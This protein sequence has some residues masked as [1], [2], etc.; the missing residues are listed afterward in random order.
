MPPVI[1]RAIW[2]V[3][4]TSPVIADGAV[5]VSDGRIQDIGSWQ[6]IKRK[7]PG[8]PV[9]ENADVLMPGLVNAHMHLE[10]SV[11]GATE[12]VNKESSMCNWIRALLKKR[13]AA[14]NTEAEILAA[15]ELA[16]VDQYE[17]GVVLLLDTGNTQL[18]EFSPFTKTPE[19]VS[20]LE[21]LGPSK[22]A[23]QMAIEAL[24]AIPA[25][26][27][28]TGHAPY[29]TA[30]ELLQYIKKRS[31]AK[32]TIFSLH[33]AENPDEALLLLQGKGCFVDFLRER[34]AFDGTFPIAKSKSVIEYLYDS[35]LLDANTLCVHCVH[36]D[37]NEIAILGQSKSHI[38]LCPK[39]NDFLNVGEAPLYKF[40]DHGI[41]PCLGTDSIASNPVPDMWQEM[42]LLSQKYPGVDAETILLMATLGGAKAMQREFDYGSLKK[43]HSANFLVIQDKNL[44][45]VRNER[46]LLRTLTLMGR[47]ATIERACE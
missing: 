28:V 10:L 34:E 27:A 30:P 11:F 40:L 16:A 35:N 18:P 7:Y 17:S 13:M 21:M 4:V 9:R 46:E 3:P 42:A 38:C 23:T 41:L 36:I 6:D 20:L 5:L 44:N 15:A 19:I 37:N 14:P 24:A 31:R 32:N 1:Y 33:V 25:D 26:C 2:V 22:K 39:S 43:G 45:Y 8:I 29:S 12:P 47:P